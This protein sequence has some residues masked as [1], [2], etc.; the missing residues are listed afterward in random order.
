MPLNALEDYN[1]N[2]VNWWK[3]VIRWAFNWFYLQDHQ[4]NYTI[5]KIMKIQ[6]CSWVVDIELFYSGLNW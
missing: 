2:N 4:N 1:K 5:P 3:K 6:K